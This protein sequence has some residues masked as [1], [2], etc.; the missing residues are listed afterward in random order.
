MPYIF[1]P[2]RKES[3]LFLKICN[4]ST[5][6]KAILNSIRKYKYK[7]IPENNKNMKNM[8]ILIESKLNNRLHFI[9]NMNEGGAPEKIN[10]LK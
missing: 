4:L 10:K 6:R 5:P 8:K 7:E 1:S 3:F 9:R 2:T